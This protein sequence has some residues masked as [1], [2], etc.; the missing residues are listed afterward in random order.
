M[1]AN[2]LTQVFLP[3]ALGI[4]MLGMGFELT[5][6]DFK[7]VTIYPKAVMTGL[8]CQLII[9]PL[10]AFALMSFWNLKPELA[11]GIIL[12]AACPGGATSNL[13]SYLSKCDTA[14]SITLTA[15][16]S[17]V[18]IITIPL[19]VN[20]G[21]ETLM[22]SGEYI[23]LPVI[24]TMI[25]IMVITL[26]PVSLGMYLKYCQPRF[27]RKAQ[28]PMKIASAVFIFIVILGTILGDRQNIIPFFIQT[29]L[30][31]FTLN[32]ITLI[33]GFFIPKIIGL[34][35]QQ[36]STISIESGIQNGTLGIAIA[37]T[38]LQNPQMAIAPAVYS[39]IMFITGGIVSYFYLQTNKK[40]QIN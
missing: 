36:S 33:T 28:K 39:L 30:P 34:N 3:F 9:I 21:M 26:I 38:I 17:F 22:G 37:T 40:I 15:I 25:Q 19:I 2:L 16:S 4:I 8:F 10:V 7:R 35:F 31:A 1:E 11:V 24:K 5:I 27:A 6:D 14:L 29:G 18:T 20:Y 13:Y 32:L 12:L 23:A